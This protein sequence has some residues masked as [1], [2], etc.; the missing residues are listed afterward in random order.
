[1]APNQVYGA[2][3]AAERGKDEVSPKNMRIPVDAYDFMAHG[4][5]EKK[6]EE[7]FKAKY[8]HDF[9]FGNNSLSPAACLPGHNC[10]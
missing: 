3:P 2:W 8:K 1:M 6:G 9:F 10:D 7:L 5:F 4:N